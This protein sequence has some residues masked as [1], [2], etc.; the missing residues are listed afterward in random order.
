M[1]L[2][3]ERLMLREM[4]DSDYDALCLMLRD[5]DVMYA[6]AHAFDEA[7]SWQWLARQ[8]QRYAE[9]GF[10]LWAVELKSTGEMIGQCGLTLQPLEGRQVIEVGYI[11][12]KEFWHMGYATEAARACRDLAFD[13]FDA[14]EVYSI[15]R[16]NNLPSQAVAR[17]LGME[18]RC[19][20][21][22]HYYGID[23]PHIAFSV[24]RAQ[25]V[26]VTPRLL[27]RKFE[28]GDA[29]ALYEYLS[30]PEVVRYEPYEPFSRAMAEFEAHARALNP[31]HRAV[32]LRPDDIAQLA[33]G[34]YELNAPTPGRLIGNLYAPLRFSGV[35]EL[36]FA[37]NRAYWGR[38][39]A[40]EATHALMASLFGRNA[41]RIFAR[42]DAEN[43]RSQQL[44]TRLGMHMESRAQAVM[45]RGRRRTIL[46]Y[47]ISRDEWPNICPF[48]SS[49]ILS[50]T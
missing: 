39:F 24:R 6:Y 7:E 47:S 4:R 40:Y 33:P 35:Y 28:P 8:Q 1:V 25:G 27:L 36:G 20:F 16:D 14:R 31:D 44:L 15:I 38:G 48:G 46:T 23:M 29:E 22:K 37:F 50:P 42:C 30:D 5:A 17:R 18:P 26:I 41:Q 3:T 45:L 34:E 2:Q 10:G 32:A 13:R 12:R 11:F 19:T 9:N 21:S 43:L 49:T